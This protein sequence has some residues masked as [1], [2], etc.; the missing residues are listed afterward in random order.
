[1]AQ[2]KTLYEWSDVLKDELGKVLGKEKTTEQGIAYVVSNEITDIEIPEEFWKLLMGDEYFRRVAAKGN[3]NIGGYE[4][5]KGLDLKVNY[6]Q[7]RVRQDTITPYKKKRTRG[8][9]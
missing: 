6:E 4:V 2:L 7:R 8:R 1:M 3:A 5:R 9:Y